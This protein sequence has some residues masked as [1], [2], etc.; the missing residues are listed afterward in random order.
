MEPPGP[1]RIV[2]IVPAHQ[3]AFGEV[4][5]AFEHCRRYSSRSFRRL[6]NAAGAE[7]LTRKNFRFRYLNLPGLFGWW[8]NGRFLGR[9]EIGTTNIRAFETL[10]PIIRPVD[11]F[12]HNR[13]RIPLGNS[14]L[15][16]T[17]SR[18]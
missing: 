8:F 2:S 3:W 1:K 6:L 10:C 13:L 16:V 15:A 12:L 9:H 14:L 7:P 18:G 17:S 4:D 5:K 11:D